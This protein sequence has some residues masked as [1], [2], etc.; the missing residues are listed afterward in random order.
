MTGRRKCRLSKTD[1]LERKLDMILSE[2]VML[3]QLVSRRTD[4]DTEIDRLHSAA[5]RLRTQ[6]ERERKAVMRW[7]R[8]Q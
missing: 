5:R 4:T 6:C 1:R 7:R 8:R 2:L 3:R